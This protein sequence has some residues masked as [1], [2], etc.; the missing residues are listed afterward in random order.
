MPPA[1]QGEP[2]LPGPVLAAPYHLRGDDRRRRRTST[3]ATGTRRGRRRGGAR[4]ARRRRGRA[5]RLR[6]GAPCAV[7]QPALGPATCSWPCDDGYPGVR[8]VAPSGSR[9]AASRCASCRPTP[10]AIVAALRRARRSCGSRRPPT[11]ALDVCDIAAVADAA[12]AAGARLAV[13]NTLATPLGQRPLDLGADALDATAPRRRSAATPTSCSAPS[14]ARPRRR[15]RCARWRSQLGGDRR[16]VRGLARAPLARR[17]STCGSRAR[18]RTRSRSRAACASAGRERTCAT[19]ACEDHPQH[20]VAARQMRRG[21]PLV[22]FTLDGAER[23]QRVPRGARAGRR[24]DELRRR[25][26]DR[27]APRALGH[28]RRRRTA[29]SASRPAARTPRTSSPTSSR[30]SRAS[31]RRPSRAAPRAGGPSACRMSTGPRHPDGSRPGRQRPVGAWTDRARDRTSRA[32]RRSEGPAARAGPVEFTR[33]AGLRGRGARC[34]AEGATSLSRRRSEVW[35]VRPA[36]RGASCKTNLGETLASPWSEPVPSC[37]E[38]EGSGSGWSI[39][40][41]GPVEVRAAERELGGRPPGPPGAAALRLPR[42]PPRPRL[43][44]RAS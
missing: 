23:A 19:R 5:V 16:P 2:L 24:G 33:G 29:S 6:H 9:R 37:L 25:A 32:P 7:L 41:C 28:R 36:P 31:L 12:H 11:P 17:R 35:K 18:A 21:G 8:A 10:S 43:L 39:R 20:A 13:D 4:R 38:V 34:A 27:R 44:A 30:R 14:R 15:R 26:L 1:D 22:G 3:G 40:L 42:A